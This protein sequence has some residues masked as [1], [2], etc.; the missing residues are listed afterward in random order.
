MLLLGP[1]LL[2]PIGA[3][4]LAPVAFGIELISTILGA[5]FGGI[6][7]GGPS[8]AE[9]AAKITELRNQVANALDMLKRFAW[10]IAFALGT[11]LQALHDMWVGFL[12]GLWALVKKLAHAISRLVT[13][14]LPKILEYIQKLRKI[15][16]DW[17]VKYIRPLLNYI[18]MV[19]KYLGILRLFHIKW[20][21]KLDG[22][23]V[24]IEGDIARPYLIL[25]RWLGAV[26]NWVNIL[27]TA[28]GTLQRAV[29][30]NT[31]YAYGADWINLFYV[32]QDGQLTGATS[33]G[34]PAGT[35]P[36]DIGT[37]KANMQQW[38]VSETG[39]YADDAAVARA[40]FNQAVA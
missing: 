19:R 9:L 18:Q 39:P 36:V 40:S 8:T 3:G 10:T 12:D 6:F 14:V 35:P 26:G 22:I 21:G 37:V 7:G 27:V 32:M 33:P 25:R 28:K 29:F 34:L 20:A 11:L 24:Q 31:M 23:L 13:E 4:P 17:Y 15:L 30:I 1:G 16:D 2:G 38:L 5:L